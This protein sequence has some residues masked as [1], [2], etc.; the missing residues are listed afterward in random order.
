MI[1]TDPY[2]AEHV[3]SVPHAHQAAAAICAVLVVAVAFI[4]KRA[5]ASPE[6]IGDQGRR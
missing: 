4:W 5:T 2:I 3:A 1:V 6:P